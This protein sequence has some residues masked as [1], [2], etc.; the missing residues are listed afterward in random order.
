M[1]QNTNICEEKDEKIIEV[2]KFFSTNHKTFNDWL[3]ENNKHQKHSEEELFFNELLLGGFLLIPG[4]KNVSSSISLFNE[5]NTERI[6]VTKYGY[7][8]LNSYKFNKQS[9]EINMQALEINKHVKIISSA[10]LFV[11]FV[12]LIFSLCRLK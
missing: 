11:A 3:N 1:K 9:I 4:I 10:A 5:Y 7:S 2:L 12:S 8:F 6:I